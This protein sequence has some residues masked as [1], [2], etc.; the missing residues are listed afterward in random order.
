MFR[1]AQDVYD[2]LGHQLIVYRD[3]RMVQE[4]TS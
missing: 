3:R 1:V 2:D 4:H